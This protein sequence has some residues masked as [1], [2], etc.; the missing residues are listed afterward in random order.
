VDDS[1][2]GWPKEL[3]DVVGMGRGLAHMRDLSRGGEA[4]FWAYGL[5]MGSR[6]GD[7][8]RGERGC[9]ER[10]MLYVFQPVPSLG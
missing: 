1:V 8:F 3:G 7:F 10:G 5:I 2:Q 9:G 6:Q 4:G